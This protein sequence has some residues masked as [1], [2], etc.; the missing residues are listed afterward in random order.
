ML[1]CNQKSYSVLAPLFKDQPDSIRLF[2]KPCKSPDYNHELPKISQF[3]FPIRNVIPYSDIN[4]IEVHKRITGDDEF[5][6]TCKKIRESQ[7]E[8]EQKNIKTRFLEY[9]TPSG[10]FSQR[11]SNNLK[12]HSG[13]LCIDLDNIHADEIPELKA[14]LIADIEID[15]ILLFLSPRGNGLKWIIQIPATPETHGMYFDAV[16][17]YLKL[18]F[19]VELDKS[20]RDVAR[21]CFF[22]Y[23]EKAF[24]G[25]INT[26]RRLD[27]AF[28]NKWSN[29][30][31]N[32]PEQKSITAPELKKPAITTENN[33]IEQVQKLVNKLEETRTDI[34]ADYKSWLDIGFALCEL[35][36]NGREPFHQIS[37]HNPDYENASCDEKYTSLLGS[38]DGKVKLGTLFHIAKAHNVL[39]VEP[40]EKAS[41]AIQLRNTS[42][43]RTAK[44]RLLDAEQQAEIKPLM[45]AIWQTGELHVLF[46]DTGA[47]KSVWATQV[48]NS[49]S[50]GLSVFSVLPN[51]NKPLR[52][53]FYDFELSDKQFQ[54][55]YSDEHG[56][57]YG[58]SDNLFIDN[59]NFQKLV[60][61]NPSGKV[62]ELVINKICA[63][64]EEL[65]PD[66][67]VIDNLTYLKTESTQDTGV[68]LDLIRKLNEL[69]KKYNLSMLILAH[70]PK[71]KDGTPLTVNELGGSKH[72]SNFVDS[73]SA[74]GKSSKGSNIRYIKQVKP[75][76]SSELIFDSSSVIAVEMKHS[77]GFLGFHY[78]DCEFES[79]HIQS[80]GMEQ[81][82]S[83]RQEKKGQVKELH[84]LGKSYRE[85]EDITGVSR[86]TVGTWLKSM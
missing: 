76:R 23:D 71:V 64:I 9:F 81:R 19:N 67:L 54:K 27:D 82:A 18:I 47:G 50:K 20:G 80:I 55:R 83:E 86:T 51:E 34:T 74:I 7:K 17:N 69:K 25:N 26:A 12:K 42:R 31:T 21:A 60:E 79:D 39:L 10:S 29:T 84:T 70:T 15:T 13:Y 32:K 43:P 4:I 11:H 56:K 3:N 72:L 40:K 24:M 61:D 36:E 22:S 63:D 33:K 44:Q 52:V 78:M 37:S 28:L 57:L 8:E 1:I 59:I 68:A 2:E 41:P 73:V 53:L 65:K 14:K 46:A 16:R 62:D 35:G 66:V 49:L 5:K 58:F 85:I 77:E 48:A 6:K 45:G 75:S 38:Y 30:N